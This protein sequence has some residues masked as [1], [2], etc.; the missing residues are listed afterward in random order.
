MVG[1]FKY[2]V[3]ILLHITLFSCQN[4]KE[5]SKLGKELISENLPILLDNLD[6]FKVS[7]TPHLSAGIYQYVG[8]VKSDQ[9][10]VIEKFQ[11]R[12]NL[13]NE[14]IFNGPIK[15]GKIPQKIGNHSV[16]LN[17][18]NAFG[19]RSDIINISFVNFI[20]SENNQYA[21][22]EVIKSLGSGAK[23]EIYYFK[24]NNGKWIF[25]GKEV[26]GVG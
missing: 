17:T 8:E 24:Q 1:N 23:F 6:Y 25:V 18:E 13:N 22:I 9:T 14:K 19:K 20:I 11:N 21:S 4:K 15:I 26:I 12:F 7:G 16:F 10:M 5:K 3:F 2:F